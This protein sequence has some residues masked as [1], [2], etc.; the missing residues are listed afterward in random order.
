[1]KWRCEHCGKPHERNDP[2]CDNCGHSEFEKAV[3]PLAPEAED[4]E[5]T[6]TYAWICTECGNDHPKHTPPCDRCGNPTLERRALSYDEDEIVEEMLEDSSGRTPSADVSY[7]EVIDAK[8][9]L[10]FLAVAALV[11][12]LALGFLGVVQIPGISPAPPV[13]GNATAADGL[14][15][16]D[17]ESAYV[18]ELNAQRESEGYAN[19]T[20]DGDV[21]S[22]AT[23]VNQQVVRAEYGDENLTIERSAVDDRLG[24]RC[25][26]GYTPATFSFDPERAGDTPDT[27][28]ELA[29]RL[30]ATRTGTSSF[31]EESEG[32][33]GVDV[34]AGPDGVLYVTQIV[35]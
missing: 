34:H 16:E 7:L 13:P 17:V 19:L 20:S 22:A 18:E 25:A 28:R 12:Y 2:P 6:K 27:E 24:D 21:V 3:V 30:V 1:M 8:L 33:V 26:D 10:L 11:A 5:A 31:E 14:A 4:E 9:A 15:L 29:R 35:C 32:L 23:Y